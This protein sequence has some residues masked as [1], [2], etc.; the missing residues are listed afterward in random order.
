MLG[1]CVQ[2]KVV[3]THEPCARECIL[4]PCTRIPI[5]AEISHLLVVLL[6]PPGPFVSRYIPVYPGYY[7]LSVFFYIQAPPLRCVRMKKRLHPLLLE[8]VCFCAHFVKGVGAYDKNVWKPET[9]VAYCF[10][11]FLFVCIDG[12]FDVDICKKCQ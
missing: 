1:M 9:N 3:H 6:R 2:K 11:W 7:P 10:M 8:K 12:I 5:Y 4:L